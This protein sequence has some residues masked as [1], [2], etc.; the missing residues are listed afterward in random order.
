MRCLLVLILVLGSH[1]GLAKTFYKAKVS[2]KLTHATPYNLEVI[3]RNSGTVRWANDKSFCLF[4]LNNKT[5][6][7][8]V[9][10]ASIFYSNNPYIILNEDQ[11]REVLRLIGLKEEADITNAYKGINLNEGMGYHLFTANDEE[12][13]YLSV[14]RKRT[15][16]IK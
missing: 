8:E 4:K 6:N 2:L 5:I 10:E 1:A 13:F 15:K 14:D 7:C 9:R 12:A 3:S 11:T 16:A